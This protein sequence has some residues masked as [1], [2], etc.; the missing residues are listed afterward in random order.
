MSRYYSL[1]LYG[2]SPFPKF[3]DSFKTMRDV[4]RW[5]SM[6]K[7]DGYHMAEVMRDKPQTPGCIGVEREL[8]K[9][10]NWMN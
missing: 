5:L 10:I 1:M 9:T 3:I 4:D 6:A 8:I 7:A 2:L